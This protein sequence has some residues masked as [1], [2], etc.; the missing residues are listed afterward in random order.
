MNPMVATL[1]IVTIKKFWN[2]IGYQQDNVRN[3]FF[4]VFRK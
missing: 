3:N 2:V 4:H 1:L